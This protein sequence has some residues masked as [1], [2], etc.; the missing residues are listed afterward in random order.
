M[1]TLAVLFERTWNLSRT[2]P[3]DL[4]QKRLRKNNLLIGRLI[5]DR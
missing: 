3:F 1:E 5:Q 2:L 4:F